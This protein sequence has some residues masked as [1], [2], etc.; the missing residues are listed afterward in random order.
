MGGIFR[1]QNG[2]SGPPCDSWLN[3]MCSSEELQGHDT[4]NMNN[5]S[6]TSVVAKQQYNKVLG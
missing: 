1:P 2:G 4:K 3:E 6:A 5:E